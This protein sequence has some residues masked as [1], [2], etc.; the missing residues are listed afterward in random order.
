[1]VVGDVCWDDDGL[2]ID[3]SQVTQEEGAEDRWE[4]SLKF[5]KEKNK[6][7]TENR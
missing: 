4:K 5:I 7:S 3:V 6:K 2:R 1:M